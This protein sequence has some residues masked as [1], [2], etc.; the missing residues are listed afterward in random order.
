MG[1]A[2]PLPSGAWGPTGKPCALAPQQR[3]SPGPTSMQPPAIRA[4]DGLREP[5]AST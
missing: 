1:R 3:P 5:V 2:C 4:T